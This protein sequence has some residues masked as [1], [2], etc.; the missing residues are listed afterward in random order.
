MD[1]ITAIGF[2]A[3]I[4]TFIDSSHKIICATSEVLSSGSTAENAHVTAVVKDLHEATR[5][6]GDR[7]PGYSKHD[8]ALNI[9][10]AECQ[11]ICGELCRLL[12]KVKIQVGTSKWQSVK[13]ALRSM[14]KGGEVAQ[15]EERLGKCR[16]QI[17]LRLVL[18][19]NEDKLSIQ[20]QL[21]AAQSQS[22]KQ[23][24]DIVEQLTRLRDDVLGALEV[25]DQQS[26]GFV[27][28][29]FSEQLHLVK[30]V[31]TALNSLL[32]MSTATH[33]IC[34]FI[35]G[36]DEYGEDS[37]DSL[38]HER[39]A[40]QLQSWAAKDGVKILVSSR[41][42]TEFEGTFSDHRRIKLHKLN[43]VDIFCFAR[44][45]FE[46][47]KHFA[48]VQ[49]SYMRLLKTVVDDS[50]GVFLW[51]RLAVR[52]LIMAVRRN[53]AIDYLKRQLRAMPKDLDD[54]YNQM[55]MS[56]SP[57]D[58][59]TTIKLLLLVLEAGP[60]NAM[61]LTWMDSLND[62]TFPM[63]H[64]IRPYTEC[65]IQERQSAAESQL[66]SLGR[67]LLE[68][69][70][71]HLYSQR[72]FFAK[73]IGFFHRTLRDF[74]S[75]NEHIRDLADRFPDLAAKMN[76][77]LY[78]AEMWF[79]DTK[80]LD[81]KYGSTVP[82]PKVFPPGEFRRAYLDAADRAVAHHT[83]QAVIGSTTAFRGTVGT[84]PFLFQHPWAKER[85]AA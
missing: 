69:S 24:S 35:D 84:F 74:V 46:N 50:D 17:I 10:A 66:D 52:S 55:L 26:N 28:A 3:S 41:P 68:I 29:K 43:E 65:E 7:L 36:L 79:A 42:H 56:V 77:R 23:R 37:T 34:F 47:D 21:N 78:L 70:D 8:D 82:N 14:R 80:Q 48:R 45:M 12:E 16:S 25:T 15:L 20:V 40:E 62:E 9:L 67:G 73:S 49:N 58:R 4:V 18:L 39:L 11:G 44:N 38:D 71:N 75:K 33:R 83:T 2:A 54:L 63:S 13:V 51:A 64:E 57:A 30:E 76:G 6:F 22:Q 5:G 85:T 72:S 1:P 32:T 60:V 81:R 53:S 27:S 31:R 59:T 19:L 61:A